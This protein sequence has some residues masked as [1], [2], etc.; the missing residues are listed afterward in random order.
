MASCLKV[1]LRCSLHQRLSSVVTTPEISRFIS[2][3]CVVSKSDCSNRVSVG[4]SPDGNTVVGW[5]PAPKFPYEHTR[6]LPSRKKEASVGDSVLKIQHLREEMTK[7]R[8]DGPTDKELSNIFFTT[9]HTWLKK[10]EKKYRKPNPPKD[11]D[12]L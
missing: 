4:L 10:P 11:R 8:P 7:Y 2:L 9:K 6:A 12:A 5:H 1:L 3:S